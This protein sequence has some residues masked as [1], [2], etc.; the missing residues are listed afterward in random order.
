MEIPTNQFLQL[1]N[2]PRLHPTIH[3]LHSF[4]V[5]PCRSL[6]LHYSG[7][8]FLLFPSFFPLYTAAFWSFHSQP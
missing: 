4:P 1:T 8:L 2:S 3:P 6:S 5:L 7:P